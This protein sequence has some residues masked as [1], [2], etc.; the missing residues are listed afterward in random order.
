MTSPLLMARCR[1]LTRRSDAVPRQEDRP[2]YSVTTQAKVLST[3][4]GRCTRVNTPGPSLFGHNRNATLKYSW[5]VNLDTVGQV[6][7][8]MDADTI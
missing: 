5:A 2:R 6:G 7:L 1:R 4:K 8:L 3:V